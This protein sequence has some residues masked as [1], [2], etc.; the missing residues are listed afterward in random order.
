MSRK[1]SFSEW[2]ID[3]ILY[4]LRHGWT[5]QQVAWYFRISEKTIF[6]IAGGVARNEALRVDCAPA[7][8]V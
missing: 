3:E 8:M 1:R 5:K 2:E 7:N 4:Y 6:R